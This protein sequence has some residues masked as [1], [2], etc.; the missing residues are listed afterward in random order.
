MSRGCLA[1]FGCPHDFR[2]TGAAGRL[3]AG[4]LVERAGG[5]RP[6]TRGASGRR[7]AVRRPGTRDPRSVATRRPRDRAGR[8]PAGTARSSSS[9]V[10]VTARRPVRLP[11]CWART[12]SVQGRRYVGDV[13][14]QSR[15][16]RSD[17]ARWPTIARF[18]GEVRSARE[19]RRS[20]RG[21]AVQPVLVGGGPGAI[22]A[23]VQKIFCHDL[24]AD[25]GRSRSS[26]PTSSTRPA[27]ARPSS[28]IVST[29][30]RSSA[31]STRWCRGSR[32]GRP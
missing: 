5:C 27:T 1:A 15:A 18:A 12:R 19:D 28:E 25:P 31:R 32:T 26:P 17:I 7:A 13:Q 6:R 8:Q 30:R 3:G 9:T 22:F 21:A 4:E 11:S 23:Q 24:T 29:A 2:D 16:R 14:G 20:A 10:R